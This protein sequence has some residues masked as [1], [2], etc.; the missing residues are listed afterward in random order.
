MFEA[1]IAVELRETH[2]RKEDRRTMFLHP[3]AA[4]GVVL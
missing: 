3:L 1:L 4:F 2:P